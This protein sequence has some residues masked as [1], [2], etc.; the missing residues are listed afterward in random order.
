[1]NGELGFYHCFGCQASGDAITF[2][3]EIEH[4]D[5]VEAVEK[6]AAKAGI[7]LHYDDEATGR[8][9]QRRNRIYDTLAAAV[10]WYHQRLMTAADAG[11]ARGYLRQERGYDRET[12]LRYRLGWAPEGWDQLMRSLGMPTA[13]LADA[14]LVTLGD[15]G[16]S[17]FFRGRLLFPIFEAGGRPVGF[18]G[19]MLPG[20]RPPKYKNSAASAVYDKS[21]VL[22]GLNWAKGSVVEREQVVV[23]EGYTDVIG[24]HAAGVTE[25]V[26]T[27]GTALAEGHIRALTRF[28]RRI[29]L[30]YD[31]D[32]AGQAA[33]DRVY[34]WERDFK[35][36]I[37]VAAFPAGADPADMARRDPEALQAAIAEARPYLGFQLERLFSRHD[38]RS[39]ESRVRAASAAVSL[40]AGH[41]NV[42]VRDQYLMLVADRCRVDPARLRQLAAQPQVAEGESAP[43][44][45]IAVSD[46]DVVRRPSGPNSTLPLA[47]LEALRL[48][49]HRPEEVARR[50]EE[51][52]FGHPLARATFVVLAS[53]ETLHEAMELAS[54]EVAAVLSRLVVEES[55]AEADEVMVRLAERAGDR[56]LKELQAD[57]RQAKEPGEIAPTIAFLKLMLEQ[58]R[59][60][61][62]HAEEERR[63]AEQSLVRWVVARAQADGS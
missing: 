19:R 60:D 43:P 56:A 42:L 30:A 62:D 52:L 51:E 12:V 3:R 17:D 2:V 24:L 41:P 57:V 20:G 34:E 27:C 32:G 6:L 26:A 7:T 16:H 8:D 45:R 53:A 31:A 22:Y 11:A 36:D 9:T 5:F 21:R 39:P 63:E 46:G 59:V 23:C 44:R 55:E 14:G 54:P 18:G 29:V 13:A 50:L 35:V 4:L 58:L 25:A 38:L 40:I 1:V 47:E 10:E 61:G 48:A 33:A 28:A 49:V 15:R 37:A